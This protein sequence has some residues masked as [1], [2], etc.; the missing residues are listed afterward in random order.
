MNKRSI[1][2]A[3]QW[4]ALLAIGAVLAACGT[5]RLSQ[6]TEDGHLQAHTEPVWPSVEDNHWQPEGSL[7]DLDNLGRM[8]PGLSKPQVYELLGRP[9]FAEGQVAVREWDYVL[10]LPSGNGTEYRTCQYKILFDRNM[11]TQDVFWLPAQ[12]AEQLKHG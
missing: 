4:A 2:P 8:M 11:K 3:A 7:P 1:L 10:K 9:H 12:C 5:S 6:I